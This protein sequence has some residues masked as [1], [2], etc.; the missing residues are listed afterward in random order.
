MCRAGLTS[1]PVMP[2]HG[3]PRFRGAPVGGMNNEKNIYSCE[4]LYTKLLPP[5]LPFL[6][7]ICTKSLVG[8]GFAPDPTG[9]AY[10][11]PLDPLAAFRGPTSRGR[12]EGKKGKGAKGPPMTLRHGAPQCLNPALSVM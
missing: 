3:A 2:W 7:Q 4:K 12:R 5:E 8:W 11:A 6:I 10:S 9:G 1:M